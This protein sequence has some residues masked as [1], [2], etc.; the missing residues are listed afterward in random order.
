MIRR[1][2]RSTRT[3]TRFPYTTLFR[4]LSLV[5]PS[6]ASSTIGD[7]I[8]IVLL[9]GSS[10][11]LTYSMG[12]QIRIGNRSTTLSTRSEE[13]TS[14]LQSLMRISYAVFSLKNKKH[15]HADTFKRLH[16]HNNTLDHNTYNRRS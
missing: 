16:L 8:Q 10:W 9:G 13:H 15:E 11:A 5:L 14:E 7:R 1:P 6:T 4:S 12:Q 3:D 2:P